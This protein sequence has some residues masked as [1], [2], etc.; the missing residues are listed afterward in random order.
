MLA[1]AGIHHALLVFQRAVDAGPVDLLSG[2]TSQPL[3]FLVF[4]EG[5]E[6]ERK[7][8]AGTVCR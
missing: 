5:V 7:T 1:A 8:H 6:T 2:P 3:P 4:S